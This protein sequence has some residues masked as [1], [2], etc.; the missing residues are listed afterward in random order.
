M[1]SS[2]SLD[3]K[4]AIEY[5]SKRPVLKIFNQNGDTI[6]EEDTSKKDNSKTYLILRNKKTQK[7]IYY[8][9]D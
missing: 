8:S 2:T 5:T 3:C 1:N 7:V 4:M 6:E 9:Y